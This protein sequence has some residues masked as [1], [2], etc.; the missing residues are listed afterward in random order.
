MVKKYEVYILFLSVILIYPLIFHYFNLF[1]LW[2]GR[3]EKTS[4]LLIFIIRLLIMLAITTFFIFRRKLSFF[5]HL[6]FKSTRKRNY[7]FS[8]YFVLFCLQVNVLYFLIIFP[9]MNAQD[10]VTAVSDMK[11]GHVYFKIF[12]LAPLTAFTEELLFRGVYYQEAKR[13]YAPIPCVLLSASLF[14]L[15]HLYL[16]FSPYYFMLGILFTLLRTKTKSIYPAIIMH[17]LLNSIVCILWVLG[18]QDS[19]LTFIASSHVLILS[20]PIHIIVFMLFFK[21]NH[22]A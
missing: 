9:E 21:M 16:L 22:S 13:R 18:K 4:F 10:W 20:I 11:D 7:L 1:Y 8:I 15:Y 19:I 2:D 14:S 12:L 6:G 17:S 5:Y 3:P